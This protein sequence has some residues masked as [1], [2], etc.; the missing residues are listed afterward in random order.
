MILEN[1]KKYNI[2]LASN[3]PRR[4]Q[5]LEELGIKFTIG[6]KNGLEET[7]PDNLRGK[8]IAI[9]IADQKTTAYRTELEDEN[10]LIITSDTIVCLGEK[11][12][13]KPKDKSNAIDML[14][15]LSGKKHR[16]ITGVCIKNKNKSM[17]FSVS[18]KVY[19][20]ELTEEEIIY[21]IDNYEPYDKAGAYGIQEWIGMVGINKIKGSY[22]NVVGLPV[23]KLYEHLSKF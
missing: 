18:T 1:L 19:F 16:V 20:K 7:Y 3:S 21:Y 13:G 17:S 10:N 15:E 12:L 2:I 14:K 6:K 8:Q 9:Y 4:A 23:Q 11:V 22:F 5:L